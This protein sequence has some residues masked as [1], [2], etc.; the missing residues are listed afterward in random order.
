MLIWSEGAAL[1]FPHVEKVFKMEKLK[2]KLCLKM[3]FKREKKKKAMRV[4]L[5]LTVITCE[6]QQQRN[7]NSKRMKGTMAL[8]LAG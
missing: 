4:R 3:Y 5:C 2:K 7:R 8:S 1:H 6:S